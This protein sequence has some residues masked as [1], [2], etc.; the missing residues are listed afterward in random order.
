MPSDSDL[1]MH[2]Q[3]PPSTGRIVCLDSETT[4]LSPRTGD[5]II[6]LACVEML[7]GIQTGKHYHTLI[8]PKRPI[9]KDATAIHGITDEKVARAPTFDQIAEDFLCFIDEDPLVIHNAEFDV[10]FL[11]LELERCH[12]PKIPLARCYCTMERSRITDPSKPA[13]LDALCARLKIDTTRR[14]LHGALLDATLLAEALS[15]MTG[16]RQASLSF[17]AKAANDTITTPIRLFSGTIHPWAV[18]ESDLAA[19]ERLITAITDQK[20]TAQ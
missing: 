5:R 14:T 2:L 16:T 4:G 11:N 13:S 18:P 20:G 17:D 1:R 19:H 3:P 6:E 12:R 7:N 9:S 15:K 8:N 10:R